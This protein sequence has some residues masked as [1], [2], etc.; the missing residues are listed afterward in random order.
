MAFVCGYMGRVTKDIELRMTKSGKETCTFTLANTEGW[1]DRKRT[2]Y[3][4]CIA[5]GT[6][7]KTIVNHF[8]KGSFMIAE[9]KWEN[10]PYKKDEKGYDIP[11]WNY[12]ITSIHFLPKNTQNQ[13]ENEFTTPTT[14]A[15][16]GF[17]G[18]GEENVGFAPLST[19]TEDLPF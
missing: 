14:V 8:A 2:D 3:I 11:S 5:W 6:M 9:G 12:R 16:I 1:G 18:G 4:R 19:S 17:V 10:N 15:D 13:E 7:A